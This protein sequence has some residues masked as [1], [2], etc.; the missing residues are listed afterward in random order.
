MV[1]GVHEGAVGVTLPVRRAPGS[2]NAGV[3]EEY[4][5]I[6][7]NVQVVC[8]HNLG[9]VPIGGPLAHLVAQQRPLSRC[10]IELYETL[11]TQIPHI[12]MPCTV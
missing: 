1:V 4:G 7:G 2:H 11:H 6:G 3:A 12:M 9:Y 10:K 5:P 8:V